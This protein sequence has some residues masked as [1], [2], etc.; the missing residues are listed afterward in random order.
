V[1][2]ADFVEMVRA[3]QS[4][5]RR[6]SRGCL[7]PTLPSKDGDIDQADLTTFVPVLL[8]PAG[9]ACQRGA[10]DMDC[11]GKAGS[12]HRP[13]RSEDAG[14]VICPAWAVLRGVAEGGSGHENA[15]R[16]RASAVATPYP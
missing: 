10:A 11:D 13:V 12:R 7:P 16:G 2:L 3:G 5:D 1:T 4:Q 15:V 14:A 8:D 6:Q 9:H